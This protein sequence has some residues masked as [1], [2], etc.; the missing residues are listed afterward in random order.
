MKEMW[1]LNSGSP[2]GR[3]PQPKLV[4]D[5]TQLLVT[6]TKYPVLIDISRVGVHGRGSTS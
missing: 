4:R 2:V 3:V 5:E 6:K 1:S